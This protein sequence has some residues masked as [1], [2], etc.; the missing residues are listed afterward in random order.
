M[1]LIY[2]TQFLQFC[3]RPAAAS[4]Y[5]GK[6][7]VRSRRLETNGFLLSCFF[8]FRI[9]ERQTSE[10][11]TSYPC[12]T[13]KGLQSN[14]GFKDVTFHPYNVSVW[15]IPISFHDCGRFYAVM[16]ALYENIIS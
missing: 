16:K 9:G 12:T 1:L 3:S 4:C 8:K 11:T 15:T 6:R 14:D 7:L 10:A 13:N 5:S 2:T